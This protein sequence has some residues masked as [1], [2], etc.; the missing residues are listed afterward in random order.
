MAGQ[1]ARQS[2]HFFLGANPLGVWSRRLAPNWSPGGDIDQMMTFT[3]ISGG[4]ARPARQGRH[5]PIPKTYERLS[6]RLAPVFA[7]FPIA[8]GTANSLRA[9]PSLF[10]GGT[11]LTIGRFAADGYLPYRD[12]W[13]LY[14]PG[15]SV[16]GALTTPMFGPGA[17]ATGI[18]QLITGGVFLALGFYLLT[19]R[20][21]DRIFAAVLAAAL[22]TIAT[23]P[24]HFTQ[25]LA[26]LIWGLWCIASAGD[27]KKVS[28]RKLATG[29]ALIGW[30]FLGRYELVIV[31]PMLILWLWWYLRPA[32]EAPTRRWIIIAGLAP[33]ALFGIYLFGIVGWE[34]AF[35]NLVDYPLRLYNKPYCRGLPTPWVTAFLS[36]FA[37]L[38]G[39]LWS[40]HE[41]T[42]GVGTY[43]PPVLGSLI[44]LSWWRRR[45]LRTLEVSVVFLVGVLTWLTWIE[46]R[47]R[48]GSTP[49]PTWPMI[50]ASGAILLSRLR[51]SRP[52]LA[53]W[54]AAISAGMI[55]VTILVAWLP[56][57]ASAWRELPPYH[58]LFAFATLE[59]EGLYDERIWEGV[60]K[61]VRAHS[62]S[63]EPIFVALNN[64]RGHFANA[65]IF[66]WYLDRPP[67]SRFI[68]FDPCLTDTARVQRMI[69][70]D[71]AK[72]R[73]VVTTTFHPHPP[74]PLGPPSLVLDN[75]LHANFKSVFLESLPP[76][77]PG[78][79]QQRFEVLARQELQK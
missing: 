17:L 76:P 20:Y 71:L 38:R 78:A 75:Y 33:P 16:L 57:K 7:L 9:P 6:R 10:D 54:L 65:P 24:H 64:N 50:L 37:P 35:L 72:A 31:A 58:P 55:L 15:T 27:S 21:V 19:S 66:Y 11:L 32:L 14:G 48:S 4:H 30:S 74:P 25:S 44:L 61:A 63:G 29:A 60:A 45:H 2:I 43:L 13:T 39:N 46:M 42:L 70:E 52:R 62:E 47:P 68:E 51:L 77:E 73:V 69:V 5:R 49:A 67:A 56:G 1:L 26:L 59:A 23:F 12:I 36:L 79:F 53:T 28:T 34:K 40:V 3:P 18:V 41:L 8:L 22:G